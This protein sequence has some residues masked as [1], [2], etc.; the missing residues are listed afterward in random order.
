[1]WATPIEAAEGAA[2]LSEV[3]E[4]PGGVDDY[5]NPSGNTPCPTSDDVGAVGA[6]TPEA[7]PES[8]HYLPQRIQVRVTVYSCYGDTTGAYCRGDTTASGQ[9]LQ[10]GLAACGFSWPFGTIFRFD[11]GQEVVCADRGGMVG[12]YNLDVW[13]ENASERESCL[14]GIDSYAEVEVILPQ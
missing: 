5:P 2:P 7:T 8:M 3:C 10:E 11:T 6:T 1:M 4:V 13:C 9:P 12:D 14:P